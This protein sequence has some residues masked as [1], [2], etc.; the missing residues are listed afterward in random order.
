MQAHF[1]NMSEKKVFFIKLLI[2]EFLQKS[3]NEL[4]YEG[5]SFFLT[6]F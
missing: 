2:S 5:N 4:L 3:K 6:Y 1:R